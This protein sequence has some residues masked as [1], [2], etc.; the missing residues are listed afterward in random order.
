MAGPTTTH[1]AIEYTPEPTRGDGK[2]SETTL[3]AGARD[4]V[5][6]FNSRDMPAV[7]QVIASSPGFQY[8]WTREHNGSAAMDRST[9][10]PY[11][12][13]VYDRGV[14]ID[15]ATLTR[16]RYFYRE[17]DTAASGK[18]VYGDS[19]TLSFNI[20]CLTRRITATDWLFD[21]R[22]PQP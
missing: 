9:M 8:F 19:R 20:Q 15:A 16:I 3:D 22:D 21:G 7:N 18:F 12:Q 10:I 5:A 11:L 1:T 17:G 13:E 14:R 2:C 4:F 6:A